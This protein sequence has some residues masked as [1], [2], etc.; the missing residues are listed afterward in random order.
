[1]SYRTKSGQDAYDEGK[2]IYY[3]LQVLLVLYCAGYI[4]SLTL[5]QNMDVPHTYN[6]GN[7]DGI[8]YS[9]RYISLYWFVG[10]FSGL[11][12]FVP[13]FVCLS[14]L[15]RKTTCC[16][17]NTFFCSSMWLVLLVIVLLFDF[18]SLSVLGNFYAKCNGLDQVDNPCNDK[19]WCFTQEIYSNPANLC[20][21]T[22]NPFFPY[23]SLVADVDFVWL[24]SVTVAFCG[25]DLVFLFIPVASWLYR[26]SPDP[27]VV[28]DV[29]EAPSP[30]APPALP[31]E[32]QQQMVESNSSSSSR[33]RFIIH[34]NKMTKQP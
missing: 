9:N 18:V 34:E 15:F 25:I 19:K 1:M 29:F 31:K 27:D 23:A 2:P 10:M 26:S 30:S 28:R 14:I 13:I 22:C 11:R 4:A 3:V 20:G 33:K 16:G 32:E 7:A 12:I 17:S 6:K 24:F 5:V 8:L 21:N